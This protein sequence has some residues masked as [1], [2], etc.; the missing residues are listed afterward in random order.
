MVE[1]KRGKSEG[2]ARI[3]ESSPL[4]A[5]V[6]AEDIPGNGRILPVVDLKERL[7]L[8]CTSLTGETRIVVVDHQPRV[9]GLLVD[10]VSQVMNIRSNQIEEVPEGMV[11]VHENSIKGVG[12]VD[13]R[14]VML[15][16]LDR[17]AAF[18]SEV[19]LNM[20]GS[21]TMLRGVISAMELHYEV[22]LR[23]KGGD[24][25]H[26][27]EQMRREYQI[28]VPPINLIKGG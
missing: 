13:D 6:V 12:K 27:H 26:N 9:L 25:A 5:Y 18:R 21:K 23:E 3:Q 4:P 2:K 1:E 20:P 28:L 15:L 22:I 24:A 17:I 19:L 16:D 8:G 10:R 7:N 11:S 14:M